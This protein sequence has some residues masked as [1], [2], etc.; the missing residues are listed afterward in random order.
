MAQT[1]K[2]KRSTGSSAPS[3]LAQG[4]LAYS[5]GSDT[6]YVGDPST[7]NTPIAVGGAIKNNAGSPVLATGV[8]AAEIRTLIDVDQ[9]GTDNSANTN[10]TVTENASTVSIASSTGTND[11][12]AA[13]TTTKAGVLTAT[14]KVKLNG[15][16][17]SADV[18]DAANVTSSLV[19]ATGISSGN[20]TTIRSNIGLGSLATKSAVGAAE[21]TDNTVGAAEL[22][23]SGNGSSGQSLVS[24]GSGGFTWTT[25][26][27]S[28]VSV[29]NLETRLGEIDSNVTIGNASTVH[30]TTSGNLTVTG[31][32]TVSGT[33]TTVNA[34][35]V[36]IADNF[37]LLNSNQSTSTAGTENAGIEVNRGS[38]ANA[39]LRW[40]E[41][42]DRWQFSDNNSTWYNI[43]K[44]SEYTN[45]VGDITG[46]TA[47]T[48]LSGGG[49]SGSVT[50]NVDLSELTDMT[51]DV[52]SSQDELILL[53]NGADRRKKFNEVPVKSF[54]SST[55]GDLDFDTNFLKLNSAGSTN[56][57]GGLYVQRHGSGAAGA[58][59]VIFW[60]E[61]AQTWKFGKEG[62]GQSIG[63][64]DI[65]QVEISST[66]GS[67][68]GGGIGYEGDLSFDLEVGTIDG[69][70]Y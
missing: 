9:S 14:D 3:T 15:I 67:I 42:A 35:T 16:E 48:G 66:D 45:N 63:V 38:T 34:E 22:N 40:S 52:V 4:E 37:M 6:L 30:T 20:K 23:V 53:D 13:A 12:I 24:N 19:A 41:T 7:A 54:R 68:T 1:I 18:T 57:N 61:T 56:S 64:G 44:P 69:G 25:I 51:A 21:I 28:D 55:A 8:T 60:D 31:D 46:V 39:V 5:K 49:S 58:D 50:L 10:I 36:N 33:T 17:S 62:Y 29:S 32:L 47:G 26:T 43:P 70:T 2:I 11:S 65:T 27:G 59:A